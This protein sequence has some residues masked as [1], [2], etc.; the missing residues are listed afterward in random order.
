MGAAWKL[1]STN[2]KRVGKAVWLPA[3]IF[4]LVS[5]VAAVFNLSLQANLLSGNVSAETVAGLFLLTASLLL[6]VAFLNARIFKLL[7]LQPMKF[8]FERSFKSMIIS[9]SMT[10]LFAVLLLGLGAG[11][12]L[13]VYN[14]MIAS[15]LAL[16]SF[17]TL[18]FIV[19]V[20]T[21]VFYSPMTYALTKYM[22]EPESRLKMLW[23]DYKAGLQ[24]C[25]FIVSFILLSAIVLSISFCIIALPGV[26]MMLASLFSLQG[27]ALGDP[28][29]LP[30]NF[31]IIFAATTFLTSLVATMLQVWYLFATYYMYGSVSAT[32]LKK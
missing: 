25:G 3:L 18:G 1:L 20:L 16:V 9:I 23:K 17:L 5:S 11:C 7:N 8:C 28:S 6:A 12:F 29:G 30:E 14:G 13:M 24:K 10:L 15:T 21:L 26:I 27:L 31:P 4:A 22:V 19:L 2:I 32:I